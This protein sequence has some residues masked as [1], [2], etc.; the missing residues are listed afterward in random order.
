MT[1]TQNVS[2]TEEQ[3]EAAFA[4]VFPTRE[5]LEAASAFAEQCAA[6]L[7]S[8]TIPASDDDE[9]ETLRRP[10]RHNDS[11]EALLNETSTLFPPS[12][13]KGGWGGVYRAG[14]EAIAA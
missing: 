13:E 12:S 8:D 1:Q 6:D 2:W 7:V 3:F 14:G 10:P 11:F 4:C 5:T 9:P